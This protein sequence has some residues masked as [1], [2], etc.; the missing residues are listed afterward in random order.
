MSPEE[1]KR[2]IAELKKRQQESV[3][4]QQEAKQKKQEA[5]QKQKEAEQKAQEAEQRRQKAEQ[6]A[7]RLE[8]ERLAKEVEEKEAE[9]ARLI[10]EE[11]KLREKL[12]QQILLDNKEKAREELAAREKQQRLEKEKAAATTEKSKEKLFRE[13]MGKLRRYFYGLL[14]TLG[15]YKNFQNI[16]RIEPLNID[17]V[18]EYFETNL[19]LPKDKALEAK[20]HLENLFNLINLS[21][22]THIQKKKLLTNQ[23]VVLNYIQKLNKILEQLEEAILTERS[24]LKKVTSP[25]IPSAPESESETQLPHVNA[26][27]K[28]LSIPRYS[29]KKHSKPLPPE[30]SFQFKGRGGSF[31]DNMVSTDN[32]YSKYLEYKATK[33]REITKI[34]LFRKKLEVLEK[35]WKELIEIDNEKIHKLP[36]VP[37]L[38][39]EGII[40]KKDLEEKSVKEILEKLFP[41][42]TKS[43]TKDTPKEKQKVRG[44]NPLGFVKKMLTL[45]LV[46]G[47]SRKKTN[48]KRRQKKL[49]K[50]KRV[51][52]N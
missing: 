12:E 48:K 50:S 40:T 31:A 33:E 14:R 9:E 42:E 6:T 25:S 4:R 35:N 51:S 38:I 27:T 26:P 23:F 8:E 52:R 13:E 39:I 7:K 16:F 11:I 22:N 20:Q 5:E 32:V 15:G 46:S 37:Q 2:Q 36:L 3:Q 34:E 28:P 10:A 24:Y 45:S 18:V 1:I 17:N 49:N 41:E 30:R 43:K 29:N 47:G 44:S 21:T 19:K